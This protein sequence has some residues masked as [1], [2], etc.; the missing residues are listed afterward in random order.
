MTEQAQHCNWLISSLL[1]ERGA[2]G[3]NYR[4][5]CPRTSLHTQTYAATT[6]GYSLIQAEEGRWVCL[7]FTV[8][9]CVYPSM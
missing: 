6:A 9:V 5:G 3:L 2:E 7:C 8:C 1:C 4:V